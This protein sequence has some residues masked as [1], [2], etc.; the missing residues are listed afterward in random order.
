[1]TNKELFNAKIEKQGIPITELS[2]RSGISRKRIYAIKEGADATASEISAL[3]RVLLLSEEE[4][5][6]IFLAGNVPAGD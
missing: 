6:D 5:I 3:S 4:M 2:R 1:M